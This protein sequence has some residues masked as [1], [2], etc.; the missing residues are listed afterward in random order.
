MI[1]PNMVEVMG[2][3]VMVVAA[4]FQIKDAGGHLM[5]VNGAI[6]VVIA[7]QDKRTS[8]TKR[9]HQMVYI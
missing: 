7:R 4:N 9:T 1:P 8:L 5:P 6:F 2:R 3:I